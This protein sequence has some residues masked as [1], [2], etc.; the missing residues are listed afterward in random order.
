M[1]QQY[2]QPNTN[3]LNKTI[4]TLKA[5]YISSLAF[6]ATIKT[7]L[8][9]QNEEWLRKHKSIK[10]TS[11]RWRKKSTSQALRGLAMASI[12]KTHL[13]SVTEVTK[14]W[15]QLQMELSI[16]LSDAIK[17]PWVHVALT[18]CILTLSQD[19]TRLYA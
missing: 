3:K 9:Q 12:T 6:S 2:S 10:T 4:S 19:E 14:E 13:K 11:R 7:N 5:T 15:S 17:K 18:F 1:T 16:T 8:S